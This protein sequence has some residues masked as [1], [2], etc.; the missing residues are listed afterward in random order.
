MSASPSRIRSIQATAAL[1]D[2]HTYPHLRNGRDQRVPN[3]S[4]APLSPPSSLPEVESP[5]DFADLF[6]AL[7]ETV[8]IN[9]R[10][11]Q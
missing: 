2:T 9:G 4:R 7:A 11:K 1:I 3:H 10:H 5:R 6:A 8:E